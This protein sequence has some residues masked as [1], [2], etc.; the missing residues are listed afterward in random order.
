MLKKS[1]P[2]H[3]I[4][5]AT[6]FEDIDLS[7]Y[8]T[9]IL[10]DLSYNKTA[11]QSPTYPGDRF[12]ASYAVDRNTSTCMRTEDIGHPSPYKTVW[13]KVDLG[14]VYSIYSI[15]LLFKSYDGYGMYFVLR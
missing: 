13:W 1:T 7:W 15:N 3:F 9:L 5:F 2:Y 8:K 6:C 11:T 10:D 14:G 4:E 12:Y